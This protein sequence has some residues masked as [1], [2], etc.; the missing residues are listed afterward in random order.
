MLARLLKFL[1][2]HLPNSLFIKLRKGYYLLINTIHHHI[3][4]DEFKKILTDQ[5]GIK[6]GAVVFIHSS[7]DKMFIS[8]PF[9]NIL[10]ILKDLVGT[11]GTLVFPSSHIKIRAED[12]L[13]NPNALFDINRTPTVRGILP[14]MARQDKDAYRSLHPTNSIVA[15][16]KY[17]KELTQYHQDTIYPCGEKSPFYEITKYYGI[18]IGLGVSVDQLSFVHCVEDVM[19]KES[20]YN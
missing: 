8:F 14:E 15:I 5:L 13:K 3:S 12:Y 10:P 4:E 20:P 1:K 6:K 2:K 18:I 16:G 19:K 9:Y 17:A 11:E 7:V